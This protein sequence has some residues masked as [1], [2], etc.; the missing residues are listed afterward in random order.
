MIK[1]LINIQWLV[2]LATTIFVCMIISF[3]FFIYRS[4]EKEMADQFN[5]QQ[6]ILAQE[7][8]T[9][10]E[11]YL[12]S[13]K[14]SLRLVG[15]MSGW[16]T[17]DDKNF[18]THLFNSFR[19][20]AIIDVWRI[21]SQKVL[22]YS[23]TKLITNY[24]D[25][26]TKKFWQDLYKLKPGD[27]IISGIYRYNNPPDPSTKAIIIATRLT[28]FGNAEVKEQN[29]SP[30]ILAFVISLNKIISKF[31]S[32]IKSGQTGYAW[33][34]DENGVLLQHP[35]HPEMIDRSIFNFSEECH[36]CHLN[37][38]IEKKL[39]V[40]KKAGI[41]RYFAANNKDKLI[42]YSPVN[43]GQ[44]TWTLAVSAPYSEVTQLVRKSFYQIIF[45]SIVVICG[46][47][48]VN[49][50][51][52]SI[53]KERMQ[54]ENRAIYADKLE[55]EVQ[56]RTREIKQEKQKLDDIVSAI[57]AE[58]F[59]IDKNFH[60]LWANEKVI[61]NYG[62]LTLINRSYC[63][64]I[65]YNEKGICPDCGAV[66]TFSHGQVEQYERRIIEQGDVRYYQITTTPISNFD[67][68]IV[69]VLI[70]RQNI[71][72]QKQQEQ[73][74]IDSERV[75]AV[76][77]IAL[78]LAHDLGNPLT[79]IAG[80]AQF[81][82]QNLNAPPNIKEYLQVINRNASAANKVIKALLQFARPSGD[83]NFSPLELK[84][85]LQKT[86]LLLKSELAKKNIRVSHNHPK[87]TPLILG[88]KS[89]LE[90]VL[91]N[92]ILNSIEAISQKG[93]IDIKTEYTPAIKMVQLYIDDNGPGIAEENLDSIF[94]PFF[95]TRVRG[96]GLGLT[97]SKKII[98]Q[99][100]GKITAHNLPRGGTRVTLSLP[101]INH[102]E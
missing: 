71:T 5:R 48:G 75:S 94:D 14:R 8:A 42:A 70:L 102:P 22:D 88:D 11:E 85:L 57:G 23:L 87:E 95:T 60:I 17:N 29:D 28:P 72:F 67:G 54:A 51:I 21:N 99:H 47:F 93:K 46:L 101:S 61:Q 66:K 96:V 53:N 100:Q 89:Q 52:F 73:I 80:S 16:L 36:G 76:G 1:K 3:G 62:P 84:E 31:I 9:G 74:L 43:I 58:L 82:L 7:T 44:R 59:V 92:I 90:Q 83:P 41:G 69:Q 39:V 18:N 50:V 81:C 65:Y 4:T 33:L 15:S 91:V 2:W 38:D 10:V 64:K 78:G 55:K 13:L 86:L 34:L 19:N 98:E 63:Y 77:K 30:H 56:E 79:I 45:F 27:I 37:F 6:L 32:P 49:I 97:I 24:S 26:L 35:E 40:E 12:I 20:T 68:E 25:T